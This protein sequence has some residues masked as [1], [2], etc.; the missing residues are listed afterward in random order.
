MKLLAEN[1]K[2]MRALIKRAQ[3]N[4]NWSG[5]QRKTP[6]VGNLEKGKA[7][8]SVEENMSKQSP[9]N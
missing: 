4:K 1:E 2:L 8:G 7:E 9:R 5:F 6:R 3:S